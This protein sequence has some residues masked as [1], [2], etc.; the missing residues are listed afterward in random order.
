MAEQLYFHNFCFFGILC[1]LNDAVNIS[2]SVSLNVRKIVNEELE[3]VWYKL[4]MAY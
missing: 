1:F 4:G 3:I 2:D